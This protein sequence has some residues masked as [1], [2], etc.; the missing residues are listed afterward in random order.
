LHETLEK[1]HGI[2]MFAIYKWKID[3]PSVSCTIE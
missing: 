3:I 1:Q 2:A